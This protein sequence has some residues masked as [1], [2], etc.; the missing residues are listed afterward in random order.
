MEIRRLSAGEILVSLDR[1]DCAAF[2]ISYATMSFS[3]LRTRRFCEQTA[4][5]LCLREEC[6]REGDVTIRAAECDGRLQLYFSFSPKGGEV[7]VFFRIVEFSSVDG[8]LDCRPLL[9]ARED[10]CL[11]IYRCGGTYYLCFEGYLRPDC[12]EGLTLD[13]LE[14]GVRSRVDRSY[15]AEHGEPLP[16]LAQR[17]LLPN[18]EEKDTKNS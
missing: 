12:L 14:F 15:L 2:G 1:D 11:E 13:L 16:T 18:F 8:L 5:L 7:S 10:L 3:D 9:A 4:V 6:D 17:L